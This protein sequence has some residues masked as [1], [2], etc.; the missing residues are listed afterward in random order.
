MANDESELSAI[1]K[2]Q[3]FELK[4]KLDYLRKLKGSGTQLISVYIP[5]GYQLHEV[6]N[7]LRSELSQASNIK[8]KTT[9]TNVM[10]ALEK[11][12]GF[13]KNLG[14]TP[15]NGIAVFCGNIS[16]NPAKVD[17]E[18]FSIIP[19]A[20]LR[21]QIY[22]CDSQFFLE[23]LERMISHT[24]VYGILAMDGRDAT[25]AYLKGTE[26]IKLKEIHSTAHAKIHVGG[27]SAARYQRLINE[28][29]ENYYKRIGEAM[30]KYFMPNQVKGVLIGGPGPAKENFMK[31]R[32]FNYQIKVFTP[33]IDVGY[34]DEA[35]IHEIIRKA[36]DMIA[37]QE[38]MQEKK[39]VER[40]I[41]EAVTGGLAVYGLQPVIEAVKLYKAEA[42]LISEDLDLNVDVYTEE[43]VEKVRIIREGEK[44]KGNVLPL[45]DYL[46]DLANKHNIEYHF[47]STN[48]TEGAQFKSMFHGIGAFLRYK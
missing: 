19:P 36:E 6:T 4:R 2:D 12:I 3:K 29:I 5:A 17:I 46:V 23:P 41:R 39:M 11:V 15:D 34:T 32:P 16:Q 40:F 20:P 18:L 45:I 7:K 13:L 30:N 48:T 21:V 8:S 33:L 27:Q 42:V 10:D 43:G 47:I 38:A 26:V 35:G 9:R 1:T 24:D 28:E 44:P 25:L 22:R 31:M 37:E 14:R